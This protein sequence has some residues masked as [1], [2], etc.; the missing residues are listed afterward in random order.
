MSR[1]LLTFWNLHRVSVL[2]LL[3]SGLFYSAFAYDLERTD[4]VKLI[5]L[6]GALFFLCYK[7]IQ[8]EKW[9]LRFMVVSGLLL[10]VVFLLALPNLSQDFYRFIWDG[11]L[12]LEGLNPFALTPDDWMARGGPPIEG[13]ITLHRGMGA[14][15]AANFSNYPPVNQYLFAAASYLGGKTLL[16]P[17]I[18]MRGMI[19]LADLGILYFGRRI[20]RK[21][22]RA[23]NMIYWYFLNP[24]VIIELTG[25]LHFEGVMLFFFVLAM[26]L[27]ISG[28]W[29]LGTLPYALSIGIKLFPL[30][31]LP[32][33][34]PLLKWRRSALFYLGTALFLA[35][36]IY[37]L[38]FSDFT[39]HYAATLKLWFSN[40]E[41]NAGLYNAIEWVAVWQGAKPWEFIEQYGAVIPAFIALASLTV[42]FHPAMKQP[43]YWFTGALLISCLYF[44]TATTIHPWY[45]IFP[46]LLGIFTNYRFV[47]LWSATVILSYSAYGTPEVEERPLILLIEY[48]PVFGFLI[49]EIL[50]NNKNLLLPAKNSRGNAPS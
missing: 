27:I 9:N 11:R 41:F 15:S 21:I 3:L 29:L 14:L 7:L 34:L 22:N 43:K 23:P 25:N 45:I 38:Y 47:I 28:K 5:T 12:V 37:P 50:R 6:Y 16:G 40:F 17:V 30:L 8:F 46:L 1:A 42:S 20:L 36:G 24:L 31:F 2:L 49:Y 18:A 35:L 39:E 10:R 19:I 32:L 33:I 13:A 48:L 4:S 26:F 44:F